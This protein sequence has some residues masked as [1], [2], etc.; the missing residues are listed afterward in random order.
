[1]SSFVF[2]IPVTIEVIPHDEYLSRTDIR[3]QCIQSAVDHIRSGIEDLLYQ[4]HIDVQGMPRVID[5][6]INFPEHEEI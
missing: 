2:T 3:E 6:M 1:M 4:D 5:F